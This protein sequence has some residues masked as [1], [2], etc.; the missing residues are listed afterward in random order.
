MMNNLKGILIAAI[1]TTTCMALAETQG[2]PN[3]QAKKTPAQIEAARYAATG[4]MVVKPGTPQGSIRVLNA[5]KELP[6]AELKAAISAMGDAVKRYTVIVED[7][8]LTNDFR[9]MH[10]SCGSAIAVFVVSDDTTPSLLVAPDDGWAVMNVRKIGAGL[11]TPDAR[12][13]FFASRCRKAFIRTFAA[14]AGGIGSTY[15]NNV[16]NVTKAADLDLCDE[17]LPYDKAMAVSKHL[18]AVGLKPIQYVPYRKAVMDGWAAA[19]TNDVQKKIWDK[20]HQ[21]PTNPLPLVKPNK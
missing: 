17:F 5:Q 3:G 15:Q 10:A 8:A 7:T 19:P 9:T 16:M 21:L 20:V 12:E 11:K 13:K 6:A 1:A 14:A 4:G 2:K 18:T